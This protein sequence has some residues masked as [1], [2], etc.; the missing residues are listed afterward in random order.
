MTIDKL[1]EN[2][3]IPNALTVLRIIVI[4]PFVYG[5]LEENYIFASLMLIISALSDA[6]DGKIARKLNQKTKLGAMLDPIAD[7]VT[8]VSVMI[9]LGIKFPFTMPFVIILLSKE[10]LMLFGGIILLKNHLDT[11]PA[12]WYGKLSTIVFY[13]SMVLIVGAYALFDF[14]NYTLTVSLLVLTVICMLYALMRYF[15]VFIKLFKTDKKNTK[16]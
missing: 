14:Q 9:C 11:I 5:F 7:K 15:M 16:N 8:L 4:F 6:L 10:V 12:E 3:N 13:V 2:I 1:K